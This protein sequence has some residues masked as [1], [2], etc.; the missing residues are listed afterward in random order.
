MCEKE[1]KLFDYQKEF[2]ECNDKNVVLNWSRGAGLQ[3]YYNKIIKY[4]LKFNKL[5]IFNK[6]K[7]TEIIKLCDAT[8]EHIDHNVSWQI[9]D[10][11][12]SYDTSHKSDKNISIIHINNYDKK[13]QKLI[14]GNTLFEVDY[15]RI[16]KFN[17]LS[18]TIK[19][20]YKGSKEW[21]DE[22][23]IFDEPNN[24]IIYDSL[25]RSNYRNR[26]EEVFASYNVN[27]NNKFLLDTLV[28][29]EVELDEIKNN[30]DTVLT[31]QNLLNMIIQIN[32]ELNDI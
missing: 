2:Y 1:I 10:N 19:E 24:D 27:T 29:L 25:W 31:R 30:K 15:R 17:M 22:F 6:N 11:C 18:P 7:V 3:K 28:K 12:L 21:Y 8:K 4:K 23:A 32:K 5:L 13:L 14:C 26:K 20:E 16:L 9:F